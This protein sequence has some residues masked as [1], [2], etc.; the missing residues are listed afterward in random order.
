MKTPAEIKQILE[1]I[2]EVLN[3]HKVTMEF[4]LIMNDYE[5]AMEIELWDDNG[6]V[7]HDFNLDKTSSV[8]L[9]DWDNPTK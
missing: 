9:G 8:S 3:K 6:D 4:D 1:D 2:Q 7:I 5:L